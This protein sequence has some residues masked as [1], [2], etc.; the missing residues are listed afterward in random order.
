MNKKLIAFSG[1]AVVILV[2]IFGIKFHSDKQAQAKREAE[3]YELKRAEIRRQLQLSRIARDE[4][5]KVKESTSISSKGMHDDTYLQAFCSDPMSP[6]FESHLK[7]IER[8]AAEKASETGEPVPTRDAAIVNECSKL[9]S[10][11]APTPSVTVEPIVTPTPSV[12]IEPVVTP[13]P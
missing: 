2:A 6:A 9:K 3:L 1:I 11:P 8:L 10:A 5:E 7:L 13:S 4:W 12:T